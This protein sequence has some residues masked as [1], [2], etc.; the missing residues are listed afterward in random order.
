MCFLQSVHG[1][2]GLEGYSNELLQ[3]SVEQKIKESNE[4]L[5]SRVEQ[6]MKESNTKIRE[7]IR[8]EN[9]KLVEQFRLESQKLG[10]FQGGFRL[11]LPIFSPG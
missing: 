8:R 6:K 10:S 2:T 5:L 9:K 7:E 3:S 11:K 1:R 4:L